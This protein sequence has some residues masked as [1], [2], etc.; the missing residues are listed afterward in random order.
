[1]Q[2][3]YMHTWY[4][5]NRGYTR[6]YAKSGKNVNL[7]QWDILPGHKNASRST[8]RQQFNKGYIEVNTAPSVGWVLWSIF[9]RKG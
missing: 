7:K 5:G 3:K 8:L 4:I 2:Y 1:M 9:I 6:R